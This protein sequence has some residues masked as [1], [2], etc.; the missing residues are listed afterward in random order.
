MFWLSA[1]DLDAIEDHGDDKV[2]DDLMPRPLDAESMALVVNHFGFGPDLVDVC[3]ERIVQGVS[4]KELHKHGGTV[5][6]VG[7][8]FIYLLAGSL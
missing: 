4:S 2:G 5:Q 6:V 1:V 3:E 8:W 7:R